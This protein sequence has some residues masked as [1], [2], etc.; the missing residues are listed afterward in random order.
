MKL[1]VGLGNP[2]P[3]YSWTRHNIGKEV[4]NIYNHSILNGISWEVHKLGS[5]FIKIDNYFLLKPVGYMNEIGKHIMEFKD[6]FK[7]NEEDVLAVY[8]ELDLVVGNYK[9]NLG[10]GS[11]I[12]N[13]LRS[14]AQFVLPENIWHLRVGVRDPQIEMSVQKT[15]RDPGAYLLEK[16]SVSEKKQIVELIDP[17]ICTEIISWLSKD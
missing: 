16:F 7:I 11:R 2:E 8:D 13:G 10:K 14:L 5:L 15:G 9:I 3:D 1:I 12:H 4:I 6:Y 17:S